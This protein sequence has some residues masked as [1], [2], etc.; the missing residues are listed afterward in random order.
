MR[1][2]PAEQ[3]VLLRGLLV[4]V[5][6]ERVT[7]ELG[8]VVDVGERDPARR[9]LDRVADAQLGQALAERVHAVVV[10][11]AEP[12]VQRPVIAVS[13][14]GEPWSAVRCIRCRTPRSP[15]ISSPPPARPG[16]PWTSVGRGT[17]WPVDSPAS[18][19]S[20]TRIR[21]CHGATPEGDGPGDLGVVGD[22]RPGQA[23]LAAGGQ[24]DGLVEGVVA[25]HGADR[26]ER[27]DV[28][29]LD[30]ARVGAQQHRAE[31]RAA[32]AVGVD[33]VGVAGALGVAVHDARRRRAATGSPS[34]PPRAGRG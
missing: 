31:E 2:D 28:V 20:R 21:P 12:L 27:L 9:G 17:P 32:L 8:E 4:G 22:Q 18:S 33:Q 1:D 6:V 26:P 29:R 5:R 24:R 3:R 10:P 34:A 25:D 11:R 7:G 30:R 15:P 14:S 23:A 16:P 19:R 13:M